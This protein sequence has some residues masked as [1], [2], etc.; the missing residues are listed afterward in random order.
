MWVS[1]LQKKLAKTA[2][3]E[4]LLII[5]IHCRKIICIFKLNSG[6]VWADNLKQSVVD[7]HDRKA[8]STTHYFICILCHICLLACCVSLSVSCNLGHSFLL[9]SVADCAV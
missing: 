3:Q 1:F 8:V 9:Y 7:E 4:A 5:I 2:E 6:M